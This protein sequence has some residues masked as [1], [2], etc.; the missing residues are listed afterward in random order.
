MGVPLSA[1]R[2]DCGQYRTFAFRP[3]LRMDVFPEGSEYGRHAVTHYEVLE[4]LG[5]V[6]W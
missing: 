3:R 6:A 4:D 2:D 1:S 5:P